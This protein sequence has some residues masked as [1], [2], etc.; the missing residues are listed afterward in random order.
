MVR[1]AWVIGVAVMIGVVGMVKVVG[2][3]EAVGVVTENGWGGYNNGDGLGG[4]VW[5]GWSGGQGGW[6]GRVE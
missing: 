1:V 2:V 6:S 3:V 5:L 4:Q